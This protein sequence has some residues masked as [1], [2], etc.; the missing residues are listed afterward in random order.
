MKTIVVASRNP[1]KI[2]ATLTGFKTMFPTEE[3]D[4]SGVEVGSEVRDQPFGDIETLQGAEN[5]VKNA[6]L[7][8]PEA[9]FWVGIEGGVEQQSNELAC[10]AWVVIQ[11]KDNQAGRGKTGIFYLPPQ[12]AKLIAEGKELGEA[13]DIIF[14]TKNSKQAGGT[15]GTLTGGIIDRTTYYVEPIIYALIPFKNPELFRKSQ[16]K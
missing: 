12:M 4:I 7:A 14:N 9:D 8:R 11:S 15:V 2:N 10:Y 1:V 3:F 16:H 13:H 6:R 5:R